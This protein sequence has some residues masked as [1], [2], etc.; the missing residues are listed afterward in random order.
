MTLP[1]PQGPLTGEA[2]LIDA[3]PAAVVIIPGSGPTDRDGNSPQGMQSDTYKLLAE[4]LATRGISSLRID[5]RGMFASAGAIADAEAVTIDVYAR[6][7][8]G[9]ARALAERTGL[10]CTW[11]A[12]HSEGGLV[13]LVAAA[14]AAP[15]AAEA[16]LCGVVL[17]AAPGRPLGQ[18]MREQLHANPMN[19]PYLAELDEAIDALE[20][21]AMVDPDTVSA[22][23][24]PLFRPGLQ[25]YMIQ[26]FAY[27]PAAV[28]GQVQLP[29]LILQGGRDLQVTLED[30]AALAAAMPAARQVTYPAMTHMLKADQPGQPFASY[31]DPSLPLV[32]ELVEDLVGFVTAPAPD[33]DG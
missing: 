13:A 31:T 19:G 26:L 18:L 28:A 22:P 15:D 12:G 25:R 23:L 10:P 16:P 3:A 11:L 24:R 2:L 30:A 27:D 20:Q 21:G 1:G 4:A 14:G 5:K 29:V 8:R 17:L 9:W 6:D 32:P 33:S 7:A